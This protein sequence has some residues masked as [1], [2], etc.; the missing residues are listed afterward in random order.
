MPDPVKSA[1]PHSSTLS[2]LRPNGD[3][4]LTTFSIATPNVRCMTTQ[5]T[6]G[7]GND[8]DR[9]VRAATARATGTSVIWAMS[10]HRAVRCP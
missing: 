9:Q 10:P 3:G 7:V 6:I 5:Q 1:R 8:I 4:S 2:K